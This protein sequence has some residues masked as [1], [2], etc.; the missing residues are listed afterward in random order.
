MGGSYVITVGD[1]L[2]SKQ[3][4][5]GSLKNRA[6]QYGRSRGLSFQGI[7]YLLMDANL[8]VMP[9]SSSQC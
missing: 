4:E 7:W 8:F 1:L 2:V 9:G 3:K 5:Q 6:N